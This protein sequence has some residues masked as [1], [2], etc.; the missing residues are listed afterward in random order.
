MAE[1]LES[2]EQILSQI[3]EQVRCHT[4]DGLSQ[5]TRRW[6][7]ISTTHQT[8]QQTTATHSLPPIDQSLS[9]LRLV[10]HHGRGSTST[11]N[12]A[13]SRRSYS[14]DGLDH[15]GMRGSNLDERNDDA[16]VDMGES[17]APSTP[18]PDIGCAENAP[19]SVTRVEQQ[20]PPYSS[21]N[22]E[23]EIPD[24]QMVDICAGN[25]EGH[26]ALAE[27][28]TN[29]VKRVSGQPPL[30]PFNGSQNQN[31]KNIDFEMADGSTP[32]PSPNNIAN[33]SDHVQR[34]GRERR[35]VTAAEDPPTLHSHSK[36]KAGNSRKRKRGSPPTSAEEVHEED[37]GD[38]GRSTPGNYDNPIDVD[39]LV[40]MFPMKREQPV[41]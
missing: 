27:E 40:G 36:P 1:G 19:G 10:A 9:V 3:V 26:H 18:E 20:R 30:P 13:D 4:L 25:P 14:Q 32:V 24:V 8:V 31:S 7:D 12:N 37:R 29:S 6:F 41:S 34:P 35:R 39:A 11:T 23:P 38:Q 2:P 17:G 22:E 5:T 33:S 28:Q 21:R 15:N 16:N